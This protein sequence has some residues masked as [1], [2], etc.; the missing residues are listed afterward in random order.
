MQFFFFQVRSRLFSITGALVFFSL[1]LLPAA[2]HAQPVPPNPRIEINGQEIWVSGTN[3]AWI[4]FARDL[5]PGGPALSEFERLFKDVRDN[6]G[7]TVRFWM[8][9]TGRHTPEWNGFTV[10]GP[11]RDAL[12][13][14]TQILDLAESYDIALLLSLWSFDMLRISNGTTVTDRAR[15]ILTQ[16]TYRTSYIEN[17]LIPMVNHVKGHKAI[18]AWEIFNE[19]EGMSEEFGW[20]ITH[21]IPM[22]DIQTFVNQTAGAIKRTDPEA[23]V[24]TGIHTAIEMSDIYSG[25]NP[26]QK[27]YYR[28]D[29]LIAAGGDSL[30]TLDFYTFHYYQNGDSPF[31]YPAS[32]FELDKP[33][34]LG[35]FF[36]KGN[37]DGI[38]SD[39][40]YQKLYDN[41]YA[42]A[43]SWQWVDW[44]QNRDGNTSTWPNTRPN[45]QAMYAR[46]QSDIELKLSDRPASFTFQASEMNIE[47][48]FS[49]TLS[50][51]T[52]KIKSVI[53]NGDTVAVMGSLLVTPDEDTEYI[54]EMTT[55]NDE[56]LRDTLSITVFSQI[57]IDRAEGA[58]IEYASD[59]TWYLAEMDQSYGIEII[60]FDLEQVPAEGFEL[61]SSLDGLNWTTF[62]P[63][64]GG[65]SLSTTQQDITLSEPSHGRFFRII[66]SESISVQHLKIY[67]V[68]SEFQPPVLKLTSPMHL[69]ETEVAVELKISATAVKGTE[70]LGRIGV[71]FYVNGERFSSKRFAPYEV[72]FTPDSAGLYSFQ[73]GVTTPSLGDFYSRP[74]TVNVVESLPKI[75]Y[76]AEDAVYSGT[77]QAGSDSDASGGSYLYMQGDGKI[78]WNNIKVDSTKTYIIR[79]GYNLPFDHKTQYIR[80]NGS[81]VDTV[82]FT[83]PTEVWQ[84]LDREVDLKAGTNV[85]EIEHFWGYMYFDYIEIRGNGQEVGTTLEQGH[86][87]VDQYELFQNYPNPFNPTTEIQY[88]LPAAQ[89]VRLEVFTLTG[90]RVAIVDQGVKSAGR[91]IASF[92]ATNLASGVYLYRLNTPSFSSTKKMLLIK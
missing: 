36:I 59:S 86:E 92:D 20:S 3:L 63:E 34:F 69:S 45:L 64:N 41:G 50:W 71:I 83:V 61:Q 49:T 15:A 18:L 84:S 7:N 39:K 5:G 82:T 4:D 48:T 79:Y 24:T 26:L 85:I 19:A 42:G 89:E 57:E 14:L 58:V 29:R 87:F 55:H 76:E 37:V 67:G 1:F 72:L 70:G 38:D 27:N 16:Q 53:L 68:P 9:T 13:N 60:Q 25:T 10:T 52:R 88:S 23:Q 12:R 28:D 80:V 22:A 32:H 31:I 2:V 21:H 33:V 51:T 91:H 56:L 17:S 54:L 6:G 81:I 47:R 35:E 40:L 65:Q 46:Y 30:G 11:G 74:V 90:N 66:A 62:Y 78:T 43:L 77:I 75:R 8:H 73:I 44:R